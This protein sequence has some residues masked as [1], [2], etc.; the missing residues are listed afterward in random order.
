[1]QPVDFL[2][3]TDLSIL[4]QALNEGGERFR[5]LAGGSDLVPLMKREVVTPEAVLDIS[6][7][8]TLRAIRVMPGLGVLVGS[9]V[10]LAELAADPRLEGPFQ[11]LVE[12]AA[13]AGPAQ[14][15]NVG[16]LGG[17]LLQRPRC[18]YF[19]GSDLCWLKGGEACPAREGEN[20][21]HGIFEDGPCVATHAS[22]LA[23]VL[24]ALNAAVHTQSASNE[25]TWPVTMFLR[26]P[27]PEYRD[28]TVLDGRELI[29]FVQLP[30]PPE[31][32]RSVYVKQ[33]APGW[34][35]ALVAV[36]LAGVVEGRSLRD[37]RLA[38]GAVATVPRRAPAAEQI[39]AAGEFDEAR[40]EEAVAAALEGARALSENGYKL[41]LLA[42][43][44]RQ[45]IGRLIGGGTA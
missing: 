18:P 32:L 4:L 45:A 28:E 15:R 6:R 43:T 23:T 27:M 19:R 44:I 1:M 14:V 25:R 42:E 21:I 29:T 31:G 5:P 35:F 39:L 8:E 20:L 17:N 24:F 7:V 10:T 30:E 37:V 13:G 11:A 16:T 38:L 36:A 41:P 26:P 12:A 9:L 22:D 40:I 3:H 2:H 34:P 33:T